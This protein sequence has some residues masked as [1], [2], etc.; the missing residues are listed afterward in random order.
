MNHKI[1]DTCNGY[2]VIY[3]YF[4]P[5]CADYNAQPNKSNIYRCPVCK[6][7]TFEGDKSLPYQA[8]IFHK[9]K[10]YIVEILL[11]EQDFKLI[12]KIELKEIIHIIKKVQS[13]FRKYSW[14]ESH[15]ILPATAQIQLPLPG[16]TLSQESNYFISGTPQI[17]TYVI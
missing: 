16:T 6:G 11:I 3:P 17:A 13:I 12:T 8:H 7:L 15:E 10:I 1:C 2:G 5:S 14:I 4:C 9:G